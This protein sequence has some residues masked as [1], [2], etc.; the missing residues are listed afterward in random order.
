MAINEFLKTVLGAPGAEALAKVASK[1]PVIENVILP[2][3]VTAWLN[4]LDSY[5]GAIPGTENTYLKFV[6]T[7]GG[8]AGFVT[9]QD[10][11][12]HFSK[13]SPQHLAASVVVSLNTDRVDLPEIKKSELNK[14]NKSVELLVKAQRELS[15]LNKKGAAAPQPPDALTPAKPPE[16]PLA[17]GQV[18]EDPNKKRKKAGLPELPKAPKLAPIKLALS[19]ILSVC[20]ECG[21]KQFGGGELRGCFCIRELVKNAEIDYGA[22]AVTIKFVDPDVGL[23]EASFVVE[24]L[25]GEY[26]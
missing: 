4:G 19:E 13:A 22:E 17:P 11:M 18:P 9:I 8:F 10:Q 24:T 15:T 23:E 16:A 25:G 6:K 14:L 3:T 20:P 2:Q 26:E 5:E 21:T 7:S 12:Y 1:N